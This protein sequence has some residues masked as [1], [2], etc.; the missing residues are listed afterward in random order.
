MSKH[1]S[2]SQ[3][4]VSPSKKFK[5]GEGETPKFKLTYFNFRW[6]AEPIRYI[7]HYVEEDFEDHRIEMDDWEKVKAEYPYGKVPVLEWENKKLSQSFTIARFLAKQYKLTGADDFESA[8]CDEYADV[9]KDILKEV[10]TMWHEDEAKKLKIKNNVLD[11]TLP[12]LFTKVEND[13]KSKDG[14]HLVGSGF[15]WVDFVLAHFT[16]AFESFVDPSFLS[17]YPTIK[18]HQKNVQNI[19]QIKEWIAKRPVTE[20]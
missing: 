9:V 17:N 11:K 18:A 19:P 20:Y 8:K 6:L 15:T 5:G 12:A 13:L 4:E 14:K 7:L 10:E 1:A 16:E 3:A 2:E